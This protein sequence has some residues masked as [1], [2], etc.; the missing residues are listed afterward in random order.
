MACP[1]KEAWI[2]M[3]LLVCGTR[4]QGY[5]SIVNEKLDDFYWKWS[6]LQPKNHKT[7]FIV[8]EGCCPDS[9]DTYAENW[10]KNRGYE[11]LHFPSTQGNYL[12]RNIEMVNNCDQVIA[13]WDGFSYGTAQ[14]IAQAVMKNKPVRIVKL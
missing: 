2:K 5:E 10:A 13:F 7:K 14:T 6:G 12:K 8:I 4:R 9:A 1:E 3:K 11:I